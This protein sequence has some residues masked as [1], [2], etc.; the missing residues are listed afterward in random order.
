MPNPFDPTFNFQFGGGGVPV[1]NTSGTYNFGSLLNNEKIIREAWE[2]CGKPPATMGLEQSISALRSMNLLFIEFA[3]RGINLFSVYE[4]EIQLNVGQGDYVLPGFL[5]RMLQV[6]IQG[7]LGTPNQQDLLITPISRAEWA[8]LP[9]KTQQQER[10]VEY[11]FERTQPPVIHFWGAPQNTNY[12]AL[13]WGLRFSQDAGAL[14]NTP[15]AA[16][17]WLDAICAG[18]AFRLSSKY[19]PLMVQRLKADYDEAFNYAAGE[20]V[21]HVNFRYAPDFSCYYE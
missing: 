8:A 10:P 15:D 20:D 2:R 3:N 17:R 18:V 16:N 12:R 19:A 4:D 7:P 9:F 11:Y 6:V 1:P 13:Y 14:I 5:A 21:E